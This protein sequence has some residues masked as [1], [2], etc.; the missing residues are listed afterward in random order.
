MARPGRCHARALALH[1]IA[2][3]FDELSTLMATDGY[4]LPANAE[5]G[6]EILA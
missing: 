2:Y 5:L 1:L 4:Q 3:T 6:P